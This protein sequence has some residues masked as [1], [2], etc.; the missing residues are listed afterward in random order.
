MDGRA[1]AEASHKKGVTLDTTLPIRSRVLVCTHKSETQNM[2]C[3]TS[4]PSSKV[5]TRK[6]VDK[7]TFM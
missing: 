1:E 2:S 7:E 4:T 6:E 3:V 5:I